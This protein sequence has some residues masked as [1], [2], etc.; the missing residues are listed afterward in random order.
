MNFMFK[1]VSLLVVLVG[2][3]VLVTSTPAEA[4]ANCANFYQNQNRNWLQNRCNVAI[5]VHWKTPYGNCRTGC[6]TS[7]LRAGANTPTSTMAGD[8]TI[9]YWVCYYQDWVNRRCRLPQ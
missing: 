9:S 5:I 2:F 1:L 8:G 7:G 4:Q 3:S 6:G